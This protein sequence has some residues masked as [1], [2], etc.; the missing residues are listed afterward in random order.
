MFREL[1]LWEITGKPAG[2]MNSEKAVRG[3]PGKSAKMEDTITIG[4]K[5]ITV[6]VPAGVEHCRHSMPHCSAA[7][8]GNNKWDGEH[9]NKTDQQ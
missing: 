3:D 8:A 2:L 6:T 5:G 7:Y 1:C 4:P 9:N